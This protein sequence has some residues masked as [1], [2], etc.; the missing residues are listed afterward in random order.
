MWQVKPC[1][2]QSFRLFQQDRAGK[3]FERSDIFF[4]SEDLG[5]QNFPDNL[6]VLE[7]SL[8]LAALERE[9]G[10][11]LKKLFVTTGSAICLRLAC[12]KHGANVAN[13]FYSCVALL[14]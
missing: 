12:Q 1:P 11:R 3:S 8:D 14:S 7:E 5:Q 2:D 13:K 9:L 6:D 10:R 4:S